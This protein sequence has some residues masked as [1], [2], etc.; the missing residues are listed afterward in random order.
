MYTELRAVRSCPLDFQTF[1][2][3]NDIVELI[4]WIVIIINYC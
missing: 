3:Y 2:V 4:L 1:V